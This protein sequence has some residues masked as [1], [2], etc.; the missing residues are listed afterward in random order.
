LTGT[1]G[2]SD[3]SAPVEIRAK[4]SRVGAYC[5]WTSTGTCPSVPNFGIGTKFI[6]QLAPN[7]GAMGS[8]PTASPPPE[9]LSR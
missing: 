3:A 5:N 2:A 1:S 9:T 4:K 8:D 6:C 7:S